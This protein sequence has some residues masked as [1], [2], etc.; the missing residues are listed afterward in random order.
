MIN[1]IQLE[2]IK[3][4]FVEKVS[5]ELLGAVVDIADVEDDFIRNMTTLRIQGYLWGELGETRTISYPATWWDAV[6]QRWF[7]R[8]LLVRYPTRFQHHEIT[9]KTLYPEFRISMP[10]EPHVLKYIVQDYSDLTA[11]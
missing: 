8:W 10:N 7:P 11:F 6:K 5:N 1:E 9:L 4:A 3:L 2:K